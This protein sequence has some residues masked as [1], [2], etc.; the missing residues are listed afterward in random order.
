MQTMNAEQCGCVQ[1]GKRALIIYATITGNS[2]KVAKTFEKV[3]LHYGFEVDVHK[4]TNPNEF[5]PI[6]GYDLYVVGTG[7]VGGMPERNL[8][9]AFGAGNYTNMKQLAEIGGNTGAPQWG[10]GVKLSKGIVFLTYGGNRRGP[11]ETLASEALLEMMMTEMGIQLMGV[12]ACP[13]VVKRKQSHNQ[14]DDLAAALNTGVEV[15]APM[16]QAY[17]DDPESEEV[18]S[19]KPEVRAA[20]K[21]ASESVQSV[22]LR[23][24]GMPRPWHNMTT[25]RPNERD[26]VKAEIFM[27][28][29]IE[30]VFLPEE[31]DTVDTRYICRS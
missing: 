1:P 2:E 14:L 13:G 16:L 27:S 17:L 9:A 21:K 10:R 23:L 19:W 20:V 15:V 28:E 6:T 30:D 8:L 31:A 22:D 4:A 26:L 7:I 11:S 5:L 24:L 29:F 3:L 25:E 12:F 18:M